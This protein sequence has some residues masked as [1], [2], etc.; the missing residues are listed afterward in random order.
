[1]ISWFSFIFL[2]VIELSAKREWTTACDTWNEGSDDWNNTSGEESTTKFVAD[3]V[4]A[5]ICWLHFVI[6]GNIEEWDIAETSANELIFE[7]LND[8]KSIFLNELL[9]L[10]RVIFSGSLVILC[11]D[12]LIAIL[13]CRVAWF[14]CC[15]SNKWNDF[16]LESFLSVFSLLR[17]GHAIE[18]ISSSKV[19]PFN[20]F[21]CDFP[22]IKF[23]YFAFSCRI[24]T[25]ADLRAYNFTNY[26]VVL[27]IECIWLFAGCSLQQWFQLTSSSNTKGSNNKKD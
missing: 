20:G 21:V 11:K 14:I 19:N 27:C 18:S 17:A 10:I 6:L 5:G 22:L 25:W 15:C 26:T 12:L 16:S 3:R 23:S 2:V 1:M 8:I 13:E 4:D 24:R 7:L 9:G